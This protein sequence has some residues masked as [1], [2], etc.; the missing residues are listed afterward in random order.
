MQT[1][2]YKLNVGCGGQPL[3][4]YINIDQD[5]LHTLKNRYPDRNFDNNLVIENHDIFNLPFASD[6]IDEVNADALLEHLSFTE[7]PLFLNEVSR[8]LKPGG[9]FRCSVP[10]FEALCRLWLEAN[11]DWQDFH[12]VAPSGQTQSVWFGSPGFD[13]SKRWGYL[14]TSF[15]GTQNASGQFHKNGYSEAKLFKMMT[16]LG[17]TNIQITRFIWKGNRDPMLSCIAVKST[18]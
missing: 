15:Y 1:Q 14:M 9:I 7:E 12:S 6:S 11:D 17:F 18:L 10:D 4:G 8:V 16:R 2:I 5:N 3:S 13:F